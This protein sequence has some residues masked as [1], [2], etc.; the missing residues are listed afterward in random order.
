MP[1]SVIRPRTVKLIET[2]LSTRRPV[3]VAALS[4]YFDVSARTVRADLAEARPWLREREVALISSRAGVRLAGRLAG[5]RNDLREAAK[6]TYQT[7]LLAA[8]RHKAATLCLLLASPEPVSLQVLS[9]KLFVSRSTMK[10]DLP[11]I[12]STLEGFGLRLEAKP[13]CGHRAVG[14]GASIRAAIESLMFERPGDVA[15]WAERVAA[16]GR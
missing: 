10:A 2:L 8:D 12:A 5:L 3:G 15:P 7:P 11:A 13:G 6:P 14:G 16:D 1:D 4:R 9:E